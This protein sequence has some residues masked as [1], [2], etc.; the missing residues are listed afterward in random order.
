MDFKR[1][2]T[3]SHEQ[4]NVDNQRYDSFYRHNFKFEEEYAKQKYFSQERFVIKGN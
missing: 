3:F 1:T 2:K 4:N